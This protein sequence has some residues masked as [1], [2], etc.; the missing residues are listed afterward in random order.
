MNRD[1]VQENPAPY[2]Q[3]SPLMRAVITLIVMVGAFMAILDTTIVDVVVPKMMAPL[4]T[5]LYGIQWVITA[6]MMA[7]AIGLLFIE[8]FARSVGFARVFI[9][10]LV[11]FTTA[12]TFC[13]LAH[14]LAE[15]IIFRSLQGLGEAFIMGSAQTLL[16]AAY[17][18]NRQGLAMGIFALGVSFAPALGP[19]V[20]GFLTEHFSWRWVFFINLPVG[21][22]NFMA[23]LFFLPN[24]LP[25]T[26]RFRFNF[27]SYVLLSIATVSLLTMLSKGQ[28]YGWFQSTLIGVL[29]FVSAIAF[30][31]YLLYEMY[32]KEPLIDF[33]IYKIPEFGLSMG[34]HFFV[35]GFAM[36]QIFYLLPLYYEHLKGLSTLDTGVHMLAFAIFIGIFS[37]I[38]GILSDKFGE[39]KILLV[40]FIIFIICSYY[41][42][43]KLNYYRPAQE[44]ALLTVPYGIALGMFFAPL[45]TLA[46][47]RLGPKTGLGVALLHYQRF[48]G[49]SFGT[50]LATNTLERRTT[51]HF[52]EITSLQNHFYVNHFLEK[53]A[54]KLSLFFPKELAVAKAKALLYQV[55]GLM[56]LSYAFEDSFRS[57]TYYALLGGI[58]LL[59]LLLRP[60]KGFNSPAEGFKKAVFTDSSIGGQNA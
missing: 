38:S 40:S 60:R 54:L 53:G 9:V 23:A 48:V 27:G 16:F 15:M 2:Q 14:T 17:P 20:G 46:L 36:Y 12:S 31:L 10:G 11:L 45:S 51:F 1:Q 26:G 3:V 5:D 7:A 24:L 4:A 41:L 43:P 6:Y 59:A 29:F 35:L 52:Q 37:I 25:G 44:A 49:G 42:L 50:A 58:F 22:L 33:S 32:S 30:L 55:Q 39:E 56:A 13:A 18:P 57:T 21:V 8:S 19:C 47:R 34:F 28:Q